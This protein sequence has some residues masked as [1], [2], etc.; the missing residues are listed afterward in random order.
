MC[1]RLGVTVR[2]TVRVCVHMCTQASDVR[3]ALGSGLMQLGLQPKSA[4]GIY[5]VNCKGEGGGGGG[6]E[7]VYAVRRMPTNAG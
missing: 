3:T 6:G 4:V 2:V 5:S 7:G 1:T